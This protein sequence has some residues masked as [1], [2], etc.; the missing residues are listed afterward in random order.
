M[1]LCPTKGQRSGYYINCE[2]CNKEVYKTKSQYNKAIHHFCSTKCQK[3]YEHD[4]VFEDRICEI[5]KNTFHVRKKLK[6]KFCSVECQNKWQTEQVGT[7]NPRYTRKTIKCEYCNKL[8]D[9]K[10]YKQ[11]NGQHNFCS[12]ECRQSWYSNVFSQ[13]D[14]WK[15]ESRKRA[16]KIL[17]NKKKDTNTKP[18]LII[19]SILDDMGVSYINEKGFV[20]YAVDNY[21]NDYNL[22]I[23]V[24]GDFWHCSPLK[25]NRDNIRDIQIK[26][27]PKDK[28]KHT[29]IK[30][31]YNIEILYLWENDI[32]NNIDVC[33][34]LIEE[35][36]H[37]NGILDNYH[38]FNYHIDNNKLKLNDNLIIPYQ[39][40]NI[41]NA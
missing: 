7:K 31:Q 11:I 5:C 38:S 19:N 9:I 12:N 15:E 30:N 20:Y 39:E 8:Y 24:M 36:I 14:N 23:E 4:I 21:L 13:C 35:Y 26:R 22:I 34:L 25:Y 40:K 28:A 3:E 41:V 32:Y 10:N 33:K 16:V 29:Y 17:E 37:N 18:Q 6:Q 2:N 27:I 1:V